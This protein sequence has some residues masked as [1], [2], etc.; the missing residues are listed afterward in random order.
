VLRSEA[1]HVVRIDTLWTK[2]IRFIPNFFLAYPTWSPK[3]DVLGSVTI[4][5]TNIKNHISLCHEDPKHGVAAI[6]SYRTGFV[7]PVLAIAA[8]D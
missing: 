5:K 8:L 1:T 2:F 3:V 7:F 4:K 6:W